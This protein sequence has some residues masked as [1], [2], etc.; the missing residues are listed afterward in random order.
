[1]EGKR[2]LSESIS[3]RKFLGYAVTAAVAAVVAGVGVYFATRPPPVTP[4]PTPAPP[5]EYFFGIFYPFEVPYFK[6]WR[7]GAL[8]ATE[9]LGIRTTVAGGEW[10]PVKQESQIRSAVAAGANG[11]LW[12]RVDLYAAA[13]LLDE[14]WEKGIPVATTDGPEYKGKR[15]AHLASLDLDL[16]KLTAEALLKA[17]EESGKPK[18]WRL[19]Y[20]QGLPG[21]IAAGERREGFMAQ[22][23]PLI[24]KGDVVIV[25]DEVANFDRKLGEEKMAA[26]LA[27]TT[28]IDGIAGG[29]DDMVIGAMI[30]AEGVGLV[31]GKD[32]FFVGIDVIP[33]AKELIKQGKMYASVT[34]APYLNA[35]WGVYTVY[36]YLTYRIKPEPTWIKGIYFLVTKENVDVF[37]KEVITTK[38]IPDEYYT[39]VIDKYTEIKK[40]HWGS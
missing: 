15:V 29:N 7:D 31:S 37:E 39:H 17:L 5:K 26:I 27:K 6:M 33:E 23:L 19:V 35:Y 3:R 10:D 21:T 38:P 18:P 8:K 24:M 11:I 34:Q 9:E 32:T 2:K 13:P 1:L 22:M 12:C 40:K 28:D 14:L 25:A 36:F 16:G 30:A 20:L 4:T